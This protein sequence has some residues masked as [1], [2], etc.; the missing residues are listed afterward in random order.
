MVKKIRKIVIQPENL[1]DYSSEVDSRHNCY[2]SFIESGEVEIVLNS[3]KDTVIGEIKSGEV[4]GL[5]P[6]ITGQE[7][8]EFY[9]T[10][11]FS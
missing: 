9:R 2:L 3:K 7:T 5:Y 8:K 6:F 11:G 4:F 1:V 10:V